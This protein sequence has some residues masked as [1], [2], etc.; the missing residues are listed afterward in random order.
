MTDESNQSIW[1]RHRKQAGITL[2]LLAFGLVGLGGLTALKRIPTEVEPAERP[3]RV[4]GFE[5]VA[6]DFPVVLTGFGAV[7]PLRRVAVS[8]EVS[9]LV[10]N[11][12]PALRVG[13]VI[14]AGERLFAIDDRDYQAAVAEATAAVEQSR[15]RVE[16]LQEEHRRNQERGQTLRRNRDLAAG[17]YARVRVLFEDHQIGN[18]AELDLAEQILNTAEDVVDE[19]EKGLAVAPLVIGEAEAGLKATEATLA[20]AQRKVDRCTIRA[21]FHARVVQTAIEVGQFMHAAM[22][23]VILADDS[24]L[25]ISVPLDARE[26]QHWLQFEEEAGNGS[27]WFPHVKPVA[28]RVRW[29]DSPETHAW[30]GALHRVERLSGET[31]MLTVVVRVPSDQASG[32]G[33]FPLVEG[34]FCSVEVP[35]RTLKGVFRVPRWAVTV[36]DTVYKAVDGRLVTQPVHVAFTHEDLALIDEGLRSGDVVIATRLSDPLENS[37]LDLKRLDPGEVEP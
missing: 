6:E 1:H 7:R 3:V 9:G 17:E 33:N 34:M 18:Q 5:L 19:L 28:C 2:G 16:R 20:R 27:A 21:P 35:G 29:S 23:S 30:I 24:V 4:D 25:E 10:T 32:S 12:H 22:E 36:D 13:G 11:V 8:A 31:R 26:A 37:L 15:H 14:P